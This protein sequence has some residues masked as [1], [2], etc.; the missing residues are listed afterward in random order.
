MGV[1]SNEYLGFAEELNG[2]D[3]GSPGK[4]KSICYSIF[5]YLLFNFPVQGGL[6]GIRLL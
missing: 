1:F 2:D 4:E 6:M 5:R 3:Q